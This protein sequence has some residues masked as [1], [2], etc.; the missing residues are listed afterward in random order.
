M[1][2]V[3]DKERVHELTDNSKSS[4]GAPISGVAEVEH[5]AVVSFYA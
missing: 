4:V 5:S 1:Y 3:D 2:Q